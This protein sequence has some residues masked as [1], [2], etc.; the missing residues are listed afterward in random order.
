M[1]IVIINT[2]YKS[3]M[4]NVYDSRRL[5][6]LN[7]HISQHPEHRCLVWLKLM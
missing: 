1:G 2:A 3:F 6:I 4:S 7:I 5:K